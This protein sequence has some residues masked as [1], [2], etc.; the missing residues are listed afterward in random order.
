M[1]K[2][3]G[4]IIRLNRGDT[5]DLTLRIKHRDMTP[6]VFQ[7]GDKVTFSVYKK[8]HMED[9]AVLLKNI[10]VADESDSIDIHFT[11]SETKIGEYINKCVEYWYEI[12]LNDKHTVIGY[13]KYGPKKFMLYP[14]GSKVI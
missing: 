11:S 1:Q 9:N 14:E 4:S 10:I 12:E 3:D 2:I 7:V 6:Y 8:W 5:L 13:D